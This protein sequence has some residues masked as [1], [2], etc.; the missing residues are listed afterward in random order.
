MKKVICL[1]IIV[2]MCGM[3]AIPA[4]AAPEEPV[5]TM[6]PQSPK[7]P[8]YSVAVYTVK[9]TG[10][11]LTVTWYIE[12]NGTT[13]NASQIGGTMQPWEV[14][15][16]EGYGAVKNDNNTFSFIFEGI[17]AELN[18]AKIWCV[19]EDGHNDVTSQT[20][21]ITVGDYSTPPEIISIPS[22]IT[23]KQ[24]EFAEIRC[25]ARSGS[26]DQLEFLWYETD[27]GYMQ[28]IRAVNRGAETS[29]YL[30]CDTSAVGT[31][32][33]VCGIST[34]AGGAAYSSV[35]AVHVVANTAAPEEP[36]ILTQSLPNATVGEQYAFQLQCSDPAAEFFPYYN[37]GS[38][39]DLEDGSWL[40]LSVDGW[41]MG[42][43]AK[44]GT[45]GFSVCVMGAGGEDHC[46]YT[47]TVVEADSPEVTEPTAPLPSEVTEPEQ[48]GATS[49]PIEETKPDPS[50]SEQ[51]TEHTAEE[52]QSKKQ[53]QE[54]LPWWVLALVGLGA[55]GI[56]VGV[57]VIL[58]KKK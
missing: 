26:Q 39:N 6:Q 32:Y 28:D 37:P 13:Y 52:K 18:G 48:E 43:P 34:S 51:E 45:Y 19:I 24:G 23:V 49:Q 22:E 2:L 54:Q 56:G 27:T 20:A 15:A 31:R 17:E 46:A 7:Y 12:W 9:A 50:E 3:L 16:G 33:Y 40:G 44:A 58:I 41:L 47:L 29:D 4:M 11:N 57:A 53:K 30:F 55:A 42:T 1:L 38:Q 21:Y 35:V 36:T 10:T 5:I 8:E 25:V 14:Y